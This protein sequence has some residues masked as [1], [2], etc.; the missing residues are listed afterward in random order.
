MKRK[1]ESCRKLFNAKPCKVAQGKGRFCSMK[2][3]GKSNV[4]G[5][6]VRCHV[7]PKRIWRTPY[8][9][10][11]AKTQTFFCG[12]R[13]RSRWNEKVMPSEEKHP[14][15]KG[16]YRSYRRR[17]IKH[18]GAVC[19]NANC[20]IP[21]TLV[22]VKMLDVDHIDGNRKHNAISNLRVLCVWCHAERTRASWK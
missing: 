1:C 16:G 3:F 17:A 11:H 15:W 4:S 5:S 10:R 13:C 14:G 19:S 6:W 9:F 2:C 12:A 8:H 18:Y 21:K 7:C 20:P 22:P